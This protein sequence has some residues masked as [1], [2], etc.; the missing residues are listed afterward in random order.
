VIG[1]LLCSSLGLAALLGWAAPPGNPKPRL[2]TSFLPAYCFAVNVAGD[3]A[4]VENLTPGSVSPHDLQLSPRELRRLGTADL[5]VVNG[6]ELEP[7][8]KR[9][10]EAQAGDHRPAVVELAAGLDRDLIR[11]GTAPNPHVW[12]D[13]VLAAHAVT[14]VLLALQ[15]S[16]PAHAARYALNARRYLGGL[17][18]LDAQVQVALAPLK[19]E[20][21]LTWHDAFPYFA[22]RYGLRLAGVIE[23]IPDVEPSPRELSQVHRT[24]RAQG[25]RVIF[26]EPRSVS[27]WA[28]QIARDTGV[29]LAELDTL[30]TG[31]LSPTAYEDG[32]RRNLTTLQRCLRRS[33]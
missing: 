11:R 3:L 27:R 15:R 25:V 6:L 16:A 24:I 30:E 22:R 33:P 9:A 26:T 2:V 4:E 1:H 13:P 12:L 7:W 5:V 29:A 23:P 28:Q 17:A 32:M 21:F 31:P 18:Q 8:L 19:E 20:P 14:N 10:L